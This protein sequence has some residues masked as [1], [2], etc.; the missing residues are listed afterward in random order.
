[1]DARERRTNEC[2]DKAMTELP[3][4]YKI[5]EGWK[6]KDKG[7]SMLS[8]I[9]KTLNDMNMY[10]LLMRYF[11]EVSRWET[12]KQA[13]PKPPPLNVIGVVGEGSPTTSHMTNGIMRMGYGNAGMNALN[14]DI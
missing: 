4:D 11:Q 7:P 2:P 12:T 13:P 10:E 8:S 9:I 14:A 3:D 6:A 1:M 5:L